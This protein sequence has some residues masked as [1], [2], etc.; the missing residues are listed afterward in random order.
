MKYL[1]SKII[2]LIC[3]SIFSTIANATD[4]VRVAIIGPMG[5]AS[6]SVGM[7]YQDS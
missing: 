1:I 5:G 6:A 4:T 2:F 7:Q 3:F